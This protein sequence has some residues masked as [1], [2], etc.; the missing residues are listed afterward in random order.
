M[1]RNL[2][3]SPNRLMI[4]TVWPFLLIVIVLLSATVFG[5]DLMSAVRSYVGGESL[6]SK[7]QKQAYISLVNYL[8]TNSEEEYGN[9]LD[10]IAVPLGDHQARL[11]L[12]S[13]K[14]DLKTAYNGFIQG[15]NSPHDIPGMIR[16]YRYFGHTPLMEEPIRIWREADIY[17]LELLSLGEELHQTI[18]AGNLSDAV[19]SERIMQLEAIN[20]GITPLEEKFSSSIAAVS[21]QTEVLIATFLVIL[22]AMLMGLGLMFARRLASQRVSSSIELR[23]ESQKNIAYLHNSSDGIHI[24]DANGNI[25]EASDSFC[26]LLGYSRDEVIGMNITAWDTHFKLTDFPEILQ[27]QAEKNSRSEYETVHRRKDGTLFD[28]EVSVTTV[29]LDGESLLYCSSRDISERKRNQQQVEHMAYHDQLTGLPNR[30]LFIDRL[31]QALETAKRYKRF[32][33]VLFID[34]DKFKKINDVHGHTVGDM[35]IKKVAAQLNN[36]V[37]KTDTVSRFGGDEFVILLTELSSAKEKAADLALTLAEKIR[38]SLEDPVHIGDRDYLTTVS[39]GVSLYPN[40]DEN[41]EELIRD[42]DIAMYRAKDTGRNGLVFFEPGMQAHIAE[43]YALEHDLRY[44]IERGELVLNLQSQVNKSGDIIAA[45]ALVRWHHPERGLIMPTNF[46]SLAEETG[47]IVQIGEWVLRQACRIISQLNAQ[48]YNIRLAVNVSP[49]QFHQ[50]TFTSRVLE[51]LMET[52]VDPHYLTLEVTE[53]LLIDRA[54]DTVMR[55]RE[56]SKLGIR[57]SIDDFGTGYS[58]LSYL[59]LMPLNEL[60]I[61]KSFIQDAPGDHNDVAL[62]ET[63]I[64]MANHLG[65]QVIAEGVETKEQY[66]FL[67]ERGC[68]YYQGYLFHRPQ[69]ASEWIAN[70]GNGTALRKQM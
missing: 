14:P 41:V 17:I 52:G 19:T 62:I 53:N 20:Q 23:K 40:Q 27:K 37:R 49:H 64:A 60:K 35:V 48:G 67:V 8:F 15:K 4:Q 58:S 28:V 56:L 6:Y 31:N 32:G 16:L 33:A 39:I 1:E 10:S 47:L 61:D 21:R 25:Q 11:A 57:F 45:E 3:D 36:H 70:I 43:R 59:K 63:V 42:A 55:M 2:T 5:L 66:E 50:D 51:I 30:I 22:T 68:D 29:D 26:N 54:N 7:G 12:S 24:L 9:F 69:P 46:I 34:L 65:Y 13:E 18:S 44:A 38:T